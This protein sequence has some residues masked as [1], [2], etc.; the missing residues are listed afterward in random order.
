MISKSNAHKRLHFTLENQ[1]VSYTICVWDNRSRLGIPGYILANYPTQRNF[2]QW[3]SPSLL[4]DIKLTSLSSLPAG[5]LSLWGDQSPSLLPPISD[6]TGH[7]ETELKDGEDDQWIRN[8]QI[9][10]QWQ[11]MPIKIA[12]LISMLINTDFGSMRYFDRHWSALGIDW[13]S[14][15]NKTNKKRKHCTFGK[16]ISTMP[17]YRH[18]NATEV[19]RLICHDMRKYKGKTTYY[20][21]LKNNT[22]LH[23]PHLSIPQFSY[24]YFYL[25]EF[26]FRKVKRFKGVV[27]SSLILHSFIFICLHFF[28]RYTLSI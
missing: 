16:V 26:F 3:R 13:G 17:G 22:F 1:S 28:I 15:D 8:T 5:E 19:F 10:A 6:F 27:L 7:G 4:Y 18:K 9:I 24:Y 21:Q 23:L 11:S 20:K 25:F 12:A 2:P 14:K